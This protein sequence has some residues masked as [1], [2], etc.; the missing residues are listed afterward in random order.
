MLSFTG[1][2]RV[3]L[4]VEPAE[5]ARVVAQLGDARMEIK[6]PREKVDALIRR[7]F[8]AQSEKLDREQL[9]LMLQGF[10]HSVSRRSSKPL[11]KLRSEPSTQS[12]PR[13]PFKSLRQRNLHGVR[14][15]AYDGRMPTRRSALPVADSAGRVD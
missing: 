14:N 11:R 12:T 5:N 9:P 13:P 1:G 8:A 6:L 4:A 2:L 10:R 7:I 15:D 3:F